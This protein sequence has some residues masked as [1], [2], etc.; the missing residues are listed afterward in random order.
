[1]KNL[2]ITF[3]IFGTLTV[4]LLILKPTVGVILTIIFLLWCLKNFV[5]PIYEL[6]KKIRK[7]F[8][9]KKLSIDEIALYEPTKGLEKL[10]AE[11]EKLQK[12]FEES[13]KKFRDIIEFLPNAILI[14]DDKG[15]V[16]FYNDRFVETF[17]KVGV[18]IQTDEF[19]ESEKFY[20]E[21]LRDFELIDFIKNALEV[22]KSREHEIFSREIKFDGK[23]FQASAFKN[24]E[25]EIFVIFNDMSSV[26]ELAEIKKELVEN[27]SHELKTTLSNIKGYIETIEEELE[28]FGRRSKQA[29]EI[30]IFLEPVKRNVDRLIRIINDL[31]ILSEVEYGI[32]LEEERIDFKKMVNEILKMYEKNLKDKKLYCQVDISDEIPT[33]WADPYRIEQMLSNLIDNA[34]KYTEKGGIKIKV[35]PYSEFS[36]KE[37]D[38]IKITIEDTGIGIPR[39]HLP[40][41]FERFYVVDKS[42]SRQSGGT[43]LG[44]S[45]VK[46]IVLM[47]NGKINVESKVGVGTKFEILLP[48]KK[49][50]N[51]KPLP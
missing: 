24:K 2:L 20:W 12:M 34:I 17:S 21:I 47:Y 42:R 15:K 44:L 27:I 50:K 40:R 46:H 29:R 35:E 30:L 22:G 26:K 45:I 51:F 4:A 6:D 36:K 28:K 23:V 13:E 16:K 32:K 25:D 11:Y 7:F 49:D 39:E 9:Q 48:V 10:L 31:L 18:L 1:M 19:K 38:A 43:G 5:K 14:L 41:I 37:P 3:L 33:F 8:T